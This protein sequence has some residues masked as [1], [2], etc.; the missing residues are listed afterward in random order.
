MTAFRS[1]Q[2][3]RR[4]ILKLLSGGIPAAMVLRAPAAWAANG[5]KTVRIVDFDASGVRKGVVEVEKVDKPA[6]DWKK[7]LT[8]EQFAIARQAGTEPPGSGKYAY[9]HA[10]GLYHCICCDIVLLT[11]RPSSNRERAGPAFGSR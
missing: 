9:N 10:D 6:A 11:R 1:Q 4:L 5:K 8:P 2:P 3:P 7:Q